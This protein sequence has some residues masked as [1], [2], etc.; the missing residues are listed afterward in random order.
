MNEK[1]VEE[2]SNL[3]TKIILTVIFICVSL[4]ALVLII[5]TISTMPS[6]TTSTLSG[7][8]TNEAYTPSTNGQHLSAWG[9]PNVACTITAVT[10]STYSLINSGNYT[11]NP[12]CNLQNTT[13][14]FVDAGGWKVN[15][16]YTYTSSTNDLGNNLT[17]VQNG[18]ISMIVNFVALMPTV[19]T[20]LAVVIL[21]GVIV[22]LVI[23]VKRMANT[24]QKGDEFLG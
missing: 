15:F 6:I 23:Y 13:S 19:G 2:G 7:S 24:G 16:T 20:I 3:I 22:L 14:T 1:Q 17:T 5:G 12:T 8:A 18:V 11:Q 9:L 4:L 10:N 21:I